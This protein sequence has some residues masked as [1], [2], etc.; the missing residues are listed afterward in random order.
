M[1]KNKIAGILIGLSG[2]IGLISGFILLE[3]VSEAWDF[4]G[5]SWFPPVYILILY[6]PDILVTIGLFLN[7]KWAKSLGIWW[8]ILSLLSTIATIKNP[9][10]WTFSNLLCVAG[11]VVIF[12]DKRAEK[13]AKTEK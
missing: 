3:T 13:A 8:G 4:L 12:L 7:W 10:I 1:T 5:L 9:S 6:L 2:L 11:A